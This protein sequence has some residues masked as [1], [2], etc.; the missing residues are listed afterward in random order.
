MPV[1]SPGV[2]TPGSTLQSPFGTTV[3][4]AFEVQLLT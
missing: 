3:F 2:E 4:S 1:H